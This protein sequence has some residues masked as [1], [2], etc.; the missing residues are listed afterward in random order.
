MA[1]NWTDEQKR[2][3][4]A[5][6]TDILVS[7]AAGSGKTAVLVERIIQMIT[8]PGHPVDVDELLVVTFTKAAASEMREKIEKAVSKRLKEDPDN[9]HLKKQELLLPGAEIMTIDSFCYRLVREHFNAVGI[10]PTFRIVDESETVLIKSDVL[11]RILEEKYAQADDEFINFT[12]Y[13]ARGKTDIVIEQLVLRLYGFAIS[14]PDPEG[15]LRSALAAYDTDGDAFEH[16]T[17]AEQIMRSVH[18][19]IPDAVT[20]S[21][22]AQLLAQDPNGPDKYIDC[23]SELGE[24]AGK[25]RD[26]K[27]IKDVFDLF[28]GFTGFSRLPGGKVPKDKDAALYAKAKAEIDRGRSIIKDLKKNMF[29]LGYEQSMADMQMA[30]GPMKCLTEL[31]IEFAKEYLKEK[32]DNNIAD[33]ADVEHYALRILSERAEDGSLVKSSIAKELSK[34]YKEILCDEYQ[35]TNELQDEIFS[36]LSARDAGRPDLFMVGDVKQSIYKF[37]MAKPEI[38]MGKY[39]AFSKGDPDGVRIELRRNFRSRPYVL[40]AANEI[41]YNIM[42]KEMGGI[43]YTSDVALYPGSTY[44]FEEPE[45]DACTEVLIIDT[46]RD[47]DVS[48]REYEAGLVARRIKELTDKATGMKIADGNTGEMRPVRN[49]DIV[50]LLRTMKGW[51]DVFADVLMKE[52]IPARADTDA[53]FFLSR[54]TEVVCALLNIMDNI[55]QD[56]PLAAV[57]RS[58]IGGFS[59]DEL[60][61]IRSCAPKASFY[62]ACMSAAE[63]SP[64]EGLSGKLKAF[65][66]KMNALRSRHMLMP[67]DEYIRYLYDE[68]GYYEYVQAMPAGSRRAG[69]LSKL[70]ELAATFENGA[71]TSLFDFL[72]YIDKCKDNDIDFGEAQI[73]CDDDDSVRIMSIHKSKGLEFPVV[74]VSGI[75]K[76]FNRMDAN[77]SIVMH[78][79][80]GIGAESVNLSTRR[81]KKTILK[82]FIARQVIEDILAEE[83]RI[84]YVAF[85]RAKEKLIITGCTLSRKEIDSWKM[86]HIDKNGLFYTDLVNANNY[87]MWIMPVV[88]NSRSGLFR[89]QFI[90]REE[91]DLLDL[92]DAGREA[93]LK[94]QLDEIEAGRVY[95]AGLKAALDNM[96]RL[97]YPFT[98]DI[99]LPAK[100]SV[101]DIKK[102][103]YEEAVELFHEEEEET[104]PALEDPEKQQETD[105]KAHKKTTGGASIG[106]CVHTVME[107]LD[108][109]AEID[110][111]YIK[112]LIDRLSEDNMI[113]SKAARY[114]RRSVITEF[115]RGSLGKRMKA[116]YLRGDL[117]REKQFILK[118]AASKVY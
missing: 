79:D 27:A 109:S 103:A 82:R 107:K 71:Y 83:L 85:T 50:I 69:N 47:S 118:V 76:R 40:D 56:I 84:L 38:F 16:S 48:A 45:N 19:R 14:H 67:I 96:E 34:H 62:D 63:E 90:E 114:I 9:V 21:K 20:A 61:L 98:D 12:E 104:S 4:D 15:W 110:D 49:G 8:D 37:R 88:M 13:F 78:A 24:I 25:I 44:S 112:T 35:D 33:F 75:T 65:F 6:G 41:F 95:D 93:E 70:A 81:K 66:E 74:F 80:Y 87:A 60:A 5:R 22:E 39:D 77:G 113:D 11:S 117:Y 10:D 102:A 30:Y 52:G 55:R 97:K 32:R 106:T 91:L 73:P 108:Y 100:L 18:A 86:V 23:I 1:V 26:C 46:Y 115:A 72:R 17:A 31:T 99:D 51:A 42:H 64:A 29:P 36:M 59:D 105:S 53:G 54:E 7:A 89:V 57:M 2:V 116:A 68:T 111:K 28:E 3:I 94:A 92:E 101:S 43:E 58:P